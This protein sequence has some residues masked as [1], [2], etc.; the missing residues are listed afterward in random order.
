MLA[1]K[2]DGPSVTRA[3]STDRARLTTGVS[4]ESKSKTGGRF[5]GPLRL[6]EKYS[7]T[8]DGTLPAAFSVST[9][10]F[11]IANY[12]RLHLYYGIFVHG[13]WNQRLSLWNTWPNRGLSDPGNSVLQNFNDCRQHRLDHKGTRS[14]IQSPVEQSHRCSHE[15]TANWI[16]SRREFEQE[17][18]DM[19]ETLQGYLRNVI[20]EGLKLNSFTRPVREGVE[21]IRFRF[22]GDGRLDRVVWRGYSSFCVEDDWWNVIVVWIGAANV[23]HLFNGEDRW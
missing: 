6:W 5:D 23:W 15:S 19:L 14:Q 21:W 17:T 18:K 10:F 12:T 20:E 11:R 8:C 22:L 2:W 4:K 7:G 1:L 3:L 13:S 9:N 16:W